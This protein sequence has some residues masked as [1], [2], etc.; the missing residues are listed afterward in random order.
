MQAW[1]T[2]KTDEIFDDVLN[3][4][5]DAVTGLKDINSLIS[6]KSTQIKKQQKK[7][8]QT[9]KKKRDS[10]EEDARME[11]FIKDLQTLENIKEKRLKTFMGFV[12]QVGFKDSISLVA[13][14]ESQEDPASKMLDIMKGMVAKPEITVNNNMPN[15]SPS[16]PNNSTGE[17]IE[18]TVNKP[19]QESKN[20][21]DSFL[22][23]I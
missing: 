1:E 15:A 11:V 13:T 3:A 17:T 19:A 22:N 5:R 10:F 23:S 16:P 21:L 7:M 18:V 6:Q 2:I 9:F 4:Y 12:G 14:K 20:P 8:K